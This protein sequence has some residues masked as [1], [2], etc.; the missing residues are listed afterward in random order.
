[1][2]ANQVAYAGV[3]AE[4]RKNEETALHNRRMEALQQEQNELQ[5]QRNELEREYRMEA[6]SIQSRAVDYNY[7]Q[8]KYRNKIEGYRVDTEWQKIV[9]EENRFNVAQR[10]QYNLEYA[11]LDQSVENLNAQLKQAWDIAQNQYNLE[12]AKMIN[13]YNARIYQIDRQY[14]A[15]VYKTDVDYRATM[16]SAWINA[17]AQVLGST[18]RGLVPSLRSGT[19]KVDN[20]R[21]MGYPTP[22]EVAESLFE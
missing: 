18:V 13:D 17:G 3:L 4:Q 20:P 21:R 10:N 16:N 1:M 12:N 5:Q 19:S 9:S 2:T 8:T 15:S 22:R 11:K 7:E 6:N 14:D